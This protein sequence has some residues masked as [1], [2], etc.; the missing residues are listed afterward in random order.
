M[1]RLLGNLIDNALNHGGGSVEVASYVAGESAAPYVVLSVL[2]RGQGIDPAEVDSIFN[3][4]IRGDKAVNYGAVVGAMGALQQ[5]GV[6]NV[7]L[8]TEAP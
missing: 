7:G 6:P 8:I 2:D 1:K 5:A 3:P 4:F